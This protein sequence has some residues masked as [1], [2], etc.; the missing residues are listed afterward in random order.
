MNFKQLVFVT[1]I[2]VFFAIMIV[3]VKSAVIVSD[4]TVTEW[5]SLTSTYPA[6]W[7]VMYRGGGTGGSGAEQIR[8]ARNTATPLVGVDSEDNATNKSDLFAWGD[9]NDLEVLISGGGFISA[10]ANAVTVG[11]LAINNPFNQILIRVFDSDFDYASDLQDLKMNNFE[12][13]NMFADGAGGS[14]VQSDI[15][16]I[17]NF[18]SQ[19]PFS[20]TANWRP[21]EFPNASDQ[22]IWIV[23]LNNANIPEPSTPLLIGFASL[24]LLRRHR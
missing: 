12:I 11:T 22:Y 10:R 1:T 21:G 15:V 23:A 17:S 18:G 14:N 7:S 24:L 16:E 19:A 6:A 3:P 13:R 9:V 4:L 20:F 8:L 5:N 2:V